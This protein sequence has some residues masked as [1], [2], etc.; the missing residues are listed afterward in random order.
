M[1]NQLWVEKYRPKTLDDYVCQDEDQKN[2]YNE[3]IKNRN[4]PGHLFL[5][6]P[7][8]TGKTT[9]AR[10]LVSELEVDENDF[11]FIN[12]SRDNGIDMIRDQIANFSDIM[13]FG[14]THK[15]ILMDEA[16][17]ISKEGQAAL[18]GDMETN[19]DNVRFILTCNF[20][21]KIIP[22]VKSRC[23]EIE[24]KNLERDDFMM[25]IAAILLDNDVE[26]ES[27]DVIEGYVQATYPDL[28]KAINTVQRNVVDGKLRDIGSIS[29]KSDW[30]LNMIELFREGK[31]RDARKLVCSNASAGE[32]EG[33]FVTLYENLELFG[34]D[35]D[36]RDE[37]LIVIRNGMYKHAFVGDPE[38][39]FS[40]TV[41]ELSLIGKEEN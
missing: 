9:L 15:V 32:F 16:D 19:A 1:D 21:S 8:G 35:D 12:A 39:N 26:V 13:K 6:G 36:E 5:H 17:Y 33:L 14:D 7:P 23:M 4:I 29:G 30:E 34:N 24:L 20:P 38:I 31:L 10:L 25:R 2:M 11:M 22:A 3:W 28:R 27:T 37:A 41:A 40:A 18:R